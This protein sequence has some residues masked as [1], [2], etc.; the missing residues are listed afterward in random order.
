MDLTHDVQ[1]NNTTPLSPWRYSWLSVF[2]IIYQS[3]AQM[4][5]HVVAHVGHANTVGESVL[6]A[7]GENPLPH[8][9]FELGQF[10]APGFPVRCST[11]RPTSR[12]VLNVLLPELTSPSCA[13]FAVRGIVTVV[14]TPLSS[15]YR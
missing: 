10:F 1:H 14:C 7:K 13:L 15:N 2:E 5:I 12:P 4:L 8:Q 3:S 11:H 9:G 6:T